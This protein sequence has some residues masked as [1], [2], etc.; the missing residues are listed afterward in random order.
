MRS[1]RLIA[2]ALTLALAAA[3]AVAAPR[4]ALRSRIDVSTPPS[5]ATPAPIGSQGHWVT[6]HPGLWRWSGPL[7]TQPTGLHY[8]GSDILITAVA[9]GAASPPGDGPVRIQYGWRRINILTDKIGNWHRTPNGSLPLRYG[10]ST[11][12]FWQVRFRATNDLYRDAPWIEAPP[13]KLGAE[14]DASPQ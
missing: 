14:E 9:T 13:L 1:P 11:G 2:A 6:L 10:A 8:V 12:Q 3:I 5:D 4:R 7:L